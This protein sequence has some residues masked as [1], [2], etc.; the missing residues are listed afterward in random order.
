MFVME[1][2]ENNITACVVTVASP[3]VKLNGQ[4]NMIV[5]SSW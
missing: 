4:H 5:F 3:Y 1:A 2:T